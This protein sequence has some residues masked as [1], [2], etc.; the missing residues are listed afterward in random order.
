M[1]AAYR[2]AGNNPYAEP[3]R[4]PITDAEYESFKSTYESIC[5]NY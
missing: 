3:D 5:A 4:M 1:G 2:P